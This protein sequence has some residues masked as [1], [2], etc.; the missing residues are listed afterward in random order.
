MNS[1]LIA[2]A[3]IPFLVG[4]AMAQEKSGWKAG[5]ASTMITPEKNMWMSGY[6]GR[7]KPSEGKVQ[8]LYA[9]A[10][11]LE[12]QKGNRCVLVSLDLVGL[13]RDT[14][15][16]IRDLITSKHGLAKDSVSLAC[17][18]THCGPVVGQ[19]LRTMYFLDDANN[20]LVDEYTDALP[21]KISKVVGEALKNLSPAD[22]SH[23]QGK[24]TFA[25]NRRNNKEADVPKLKEA[26]AIKG[27]FDH[28]VP[29]LQVKDGNGKLKAIVFGYACHATT[30]GFQQWCGD[31]PGY[32][33]AELEKRHPG[34]IALFWAGCGADQNPIPRRTLELAIEYGKHLADSV[35]KV[36]SQKM[37]PIQGSLSKNYS[38]ISLTFADLPTREQLVQTAMGTDK[39]QAGRAKYLLKVLE[40]EGSLKQE[41]PYPIQTWKLGNGPQWI[42]LGGEVVVDYVLR[43]KQ[44]LGN[45]PW[46]CAYAN[47][48][49]AY[50]PSVR[51]LKEGGYEG[52]GSMVYYGQPAFWAPSV[53]ERIITEV[54]RQATP[55]ESNQ[56]S[57]NQTLKKRGLV[58]RLFEKVRG[59]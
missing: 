5:V 1:R 33:M 28:S 49:M 19:N 27:P 55:A 36:L 32:A 57:E 29:V 31:Y 51:V 50:I 38:E 24:A 13:D 54:K 47:D 11:A 16:K 34:A 18:H 52:G 43:I 12:D 30:L 9:K 41:Y 7:T 23:A 59:K 15:N 35:D 3:M 14:S 20:K 56:M 48:V 8:D 39:F 37:T 40:K 2:L 17:S 58:H 45:N 44:E 22:I 26:D 6:G 4:I 46:V 53:E 21:A 25:V 10:V 42:F